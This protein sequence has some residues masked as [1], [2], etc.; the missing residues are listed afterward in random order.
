MTTTNK[1]NAVFS[2]RYLWPLHLFFI[3][4]FIFFCARK[5]LTPNN[6]N[7]NHVRVVQY[8]AVENYVKIAKNAYET[9]RPLLRE[10]NSA[11]QYERFEAGHN[12]PGY[13]ILVSYIPILGY[14][15]NSKY[16]F[17]KLNL[18]LLWLAI[19]LFVIVTI[20]YFNTPLTTLFIL[21]LITLYLYK[22]GLKDTVALTDQH[23]L[24][25]P[26]ALF[27]LTLSLV[28][29]KQ[30]KFHWMAYIGM[31]F[32]GGVLATFRNYLGYIALYTILAHM[33]YLIYTQKPRKKIIVYSLV[34]FPLLLIVKSWSYW[35]PQRVANWHASHEQVRPSEFN[36]ETS[37]IKHLKNENNYGHPVWHNMYQGLG[38]YPNAWNILWLDEDTYEATEK[39]N[40]TIPEPERKD[41]WETTKIL[42][43]KYIAEH[44]KEA[45]S[46]YAR[47]IYEIYKRAILLN[48]YPLT[49]L[50]ILL[51]LRTI[52]SFNLKKQVSL[53]HLAQFFIIGSS[54]TLFFSMIPIITALHFSK[55]FDTSFCF[56]IIFL[57]MH[58]QKEIYEMTKERVLKL[59][60]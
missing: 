58:Y 23:G 47:K 56:F 27:L 35:L 15:L 40:L 30:K 20:N 34:I 38:V 52:L 14:E 59:P 8:D 49:F 48:L 24:S 31:A 55:D 1:I 3:V 28:L 21:P 6:F 9:G 25:A 41:H 44:P 13:P 45:I 43:F 54:V 10:K 22:F 5:K 53:Q 60:F 29:S 46:N 57:A 2:S 42:Y 37:P 17:A 11:G 51:G 26:L 33:G 16:D 19:V 32:I 50:F 36:Y 12:D 7:S 18:T 4:L 39:Y